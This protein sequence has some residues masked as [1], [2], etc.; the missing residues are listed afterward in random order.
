MKAQD[1]LI[2]AAIILNC[3]CKPISP[4]PAPAPVNVSETNQ[5]QAMPSPGGAATKQAASPVAESS[6]STPK[7]PDLMPPSRNGSEITF[8][9]SNPGV[10]PSGANIVSYNLQIASPG[11]NSADPVILF[12]GNLAGLSKTVT[13]L[14]GQR[15]FAKV[16]AVDA[17]GNTSD[18]SPAS[19][20]VIVDTESPADPTGVR[21][22][23]Q[24]DP[25][26]VL[27][28]VEWQESHDNVT[29]PPQMTYFTCSSKAAADID[30]LGKCQN[31]AASGEVPSVKGRNSMQLRKSAA[32]ANGVMY[33]RV[34]A[35]DEAGNKSISNMLLAEFVTPALSPAD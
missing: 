22:I 33:Y 24:S 14:N 8:S 29:A 21:V 6:P 11:V 9:W 28:T 18:F 30:T 3:A 1:V 20:G 34:I 35:Q 17:N 19:Q 10:T 23:M 2:I 25:A 32:E 5:F 31:P 13:G 15:Y 12:S 26:G 27:V 16:Q 7:A 4:A